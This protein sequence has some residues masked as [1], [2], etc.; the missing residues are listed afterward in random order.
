MYDYKV[1]QSSIFFDFAKQSASGSPDGSLPHNTE[2]FI[3]DVDG[4]HFESSRHGRCLVLKSMPIVN[5][6]EESLEKLP[7][8]NI[9][10][11][12]LNRRVTN[13]NPEL[14]PEGIKHRCCIQ[15][16]G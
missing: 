11:D 13:A 12:H 7:P 1:S 2:Q 8:F 16:T 15:Y 5:D 10:L 4:I 6:M 9:L 14:T 3:M